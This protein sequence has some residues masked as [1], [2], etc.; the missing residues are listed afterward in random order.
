[1]ARAQAGDLDA[2][3]QLYARCQP[4]V[5]ALA[6][7]YLP[8]HADDVTQD[9]FV[10]ALANLGDW[11]DQGKDPLAWLFTI[12]VNTCRS[13]ARSAHEQRSRPMSFDDQHDLAEPDRSPGPEQLVL[14][15]LT[16]REVLTALAA[17][18][19][20]QREVIVMAHFKEMRGR[21]IAE[22]LGVNEGAVKARLLKARR[23][24]AAAL[25]DRRAVL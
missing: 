20:R 14:D 16:R 4:R 10:K 7:K 8:D 17:L 6:R 19:K 1:M 18:T 5:L 24:L 2:F 25:A 21:E 12:T 11:R 13:K 22:A 15:D 9:V 23:A 3:G